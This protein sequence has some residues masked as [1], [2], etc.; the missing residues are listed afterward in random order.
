MLGDIGLRKLYL[1]SAFNNSQ[2]SDSIA[3]RFET[4]YTISFHNTS[5]W[6]IDISSSL[7]LCR[8][9]S[10]I[11]GVEHI[12]SPLEQCAKKNTRKKGYNFKTRNPCI[13]AFRVLFH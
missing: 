7:L 11:P 5:W 3:D 2:F 12:T 13:P 6:Q 9:L 8:H 10:C 4:T 1:N